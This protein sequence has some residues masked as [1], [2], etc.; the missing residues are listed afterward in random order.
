MRALYTLLV[1]P[2]AAA[3]CRC[4]SGGAAAASP[5]IASTSA[6]ASA[7]T[8]APRRAAPVLWMHAVSLG[9]TRAAAPLVER[10]RARYP[11]GDDAADAHDG[12]RPRGRARALRRPRRAGVAALRRCRSRCA[13]SSRTSSP[14]AGLLMETELWPNLVALARAARRAALPRQRADVGALGRAATRAFPSLARPMLA[15]AGRRRGADATPT[16]ARLAALGAPHAGRHRQSQVRRRASPD[17]ARALGRELRVRFGETRPVWRRRLDARR[18]GGADPRRARARA[19][20][21]RSTLTV[22]VPRHPQRFAAVAELLR[23]RGIPFVAAQRAMRRCPPTSASCSATRWARWPRYYAAADV[24][25]V[26]GSL[27]PLGGQNLIEPIAVG[28]PDARRSAHVQLR[29]SDREARSRRAPRSRSPT[30]ARWSRRS[31]ALL[32]DPRAARRDA[33]RRARLPRRAP[34]RGRPALGVA[35]AAAR[36]ARRATARRGVSPAAGG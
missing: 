32:G 10:L 34:R 35:R 36:G 7:A 21:R 33:R 11:D 12:D 18:R 27:L 8:A 22:I 16:R 17:A 28:T 30:R 15:R 2:R 20:C 4:G 5:A 13:R 14:R 26:G 29:R 25:F 9:E 19:R 1:V 31:A 24:A 6:S 3:R 23:Q